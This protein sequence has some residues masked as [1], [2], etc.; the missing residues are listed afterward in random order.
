MANI[1]ITGNIVVDDYA[2][3][4]AKQPTGNT[5]KLFDDEILEDVYV[6]REG[7]EAMIVFDDTSVIYLPYDAFVEE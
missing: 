7:V 6:D 3:E 5:R 2:S 4:H 1:R